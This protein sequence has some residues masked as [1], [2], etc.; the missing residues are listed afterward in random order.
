MD[1]FIFLYAAA[2][3]LVGLLSTRLMKV[4]RMPFVT[5]YII[6]G[7]L[8]G[9]FVFGLFFNG[10][11]FL[12]AESG[13][14]AEYVRNLGWVNNV[15][16]GFIAFSVGASF[17]RNTLK[18]VGKK[19]LIITVL[20]AVFASL[21]VIAALLVAYFIFPNDIPI[22]LVLTLG[23]IAAATAPAATLMVVKQYRA[24]GPVT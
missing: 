12:N 10:F 5:G 4:I 21:L 6:T 23:A 8:M 2:I 20:E 14:V 24:K 3:V 7:I 1:G 16:L 13:P 15:A 9:P 22:P 11:D 17:K 19:V 18:A